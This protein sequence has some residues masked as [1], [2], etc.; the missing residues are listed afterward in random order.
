MFFRLDEDP[1][2]K[3]FPA[4]QAAVEALAS[5]MAVLCL[6]DFVRLALG[7]AQR[8]V[9]ILTLTATLGYCAVPEGDDTGI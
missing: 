7:Q 4:F 9:A 8:C 5:G 6:L 1:K 3:P 2:A